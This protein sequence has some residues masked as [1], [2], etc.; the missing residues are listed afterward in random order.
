[1]LKSMHR[2]KLA[3]TT[4]NM[5]GIGGFRILFPCVLLV[6][7]PSL[8]RCSWEFKI[9]VEFSCLEDFDWTRLGSQPDM[10]VPTL[11]HLK[12]IL[13]VDLLNALKLIN[14]GLGINLKKMNLRLF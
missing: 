2:T 3:F 10:D 11:K 6:C 14:F 13:G 5:T 12:F 1:M 7:A 8:C 9:V 4:T